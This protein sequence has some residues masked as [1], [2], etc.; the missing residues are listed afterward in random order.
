VT[1][2]P[3]GSDPPRLAH[4]GWAERFPWLVQGITCRGEDQQWDLALFGAARANSSAYDR[5]WTF[6]DAL[7]GNVAVLGRQRHGSRVS[8]QR[9]GG[10]GLRLVREADGHLTAEPGIVLCVTVADC[11]PV[12]LVAPEAPGVALLHAGWRGT[13]RGILERG[14][15]ALARRLGAAASDLHLHLGPAICGR[16][17]EVGPEVHRALGLEEPR[18]PEAVDLR[19]VLVRRGVAAGVPEERITVSSHCTRCGEAPLFSHRGGD[20]ER[21]VAFLALGGPARG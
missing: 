7:A 8:M 12:Y 18:S 9:G 13:A 19:C 16:C 15:E 4:P 14:V 17:Y 5:W 6:L 1:E 2:R 11:V 20:A 3:V 21:Q 10:A